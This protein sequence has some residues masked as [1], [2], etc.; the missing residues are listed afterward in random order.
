MIIQD[1]GSRVERNYDKRIANAGEVNLKREG[2]QGILQ[3][4]KVC[5]KSGYRY[6]SN[7]DLYTDTLPEPVSA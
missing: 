4:L 1:T 5:S 3:D 6:C 7:P 2:L